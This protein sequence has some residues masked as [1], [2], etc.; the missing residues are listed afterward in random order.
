MIDKWQSEL[1]AAAHKDKVAILSSFFKTAPGEYAEDDIFIGVN[2]PDNRAISRKY[3]NAPLSDVRQ[4]LYSPIHEHRLSALLCLVDRYKSQPQEI[5]NF[6]L[7]NTCQINNWDLVDLSAPKII[8]EELRNGRCKDVIRKLSV[9]DCLW[10]RRIAMVA[11]L[12][13]VTKDAC[14]VDALV[15]AQQLLGDRHQLMHKA[16]GWILREIGK[17]NIEVL[18]DFMQ[19]HIN[20]F[21]ATTLSYATE[22]MSVDE[23][24][25]W[26]M[27]R[28]AHIQN[29]RRPR[30]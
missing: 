22:K 8:G 5:V 3:F 24:K 15:L 23:R 27:L 30:K 11:T 2:V 26:R 28:N 29:V 17:K 12:Q 13:P 16:V 21:S 14:F 7:S 6:Y 9:S 18:R 20:D 10:E 1:S 19:K 25:Q 4:M